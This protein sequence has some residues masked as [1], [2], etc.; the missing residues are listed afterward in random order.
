MK[1]FT[2]DL[3]RSLSRRC[4]PFEYMDCLSAILKKHLS[5]ELVQ[6]LKVHHTK[7]AYLTKHAISESYQRE[8]VRLLHGCD[9]FTLGFDETEINK[10]SEL[11]LLVKIAHPKVGIQ[12]HH[13]KKVGFRKWHC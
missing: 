7:A 11:E 2:L 4:I 8:T 10:I 1:E 6:D 9:A 3:V 13:Y 12:L 5:D